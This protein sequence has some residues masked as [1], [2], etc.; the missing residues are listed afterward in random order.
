MIYSKLLVTLSILFFTSNSGFD[1]TLQDQKAAAKILTLNQT[2]DRPISAGESHHYQL[3]LN[4]GDFARVIINQRAI[5]LVETVTNSAG[6]KLPDIDGPYGL[7]GPETVLI[8]AETPGNYGIEVKTLLKQTTTG[9]YEIRFAELRT[10][11]DADKERVAAQ[12]AFYEAIQISRQPAPDARQKSLA[13]YETALG[14]WRKVADRTGE[15]LALHGI[16]RLH[17]MSGDS[18]KA[19]IYLGQAL[20]IWRD[21]GIRQAEAS[22]LNNIGISHTAL[23]D[24]QQVVDNLSQSLVLYRETGDRRGEAFVNN[25]LCLSYRRLGDYQ[26]ALAHCQQSLDMQRAMGD[27]RSE[28]ENLNNLGLVHKSLGDYAKALEFFSQS[29]EIKRSLKDQRGQLSGLSNLGQIYLLTGDP[30]KALEYHTQALE[31]SRSVGERRAE[32]V[33]FNNLGSVH[34][35]LGEH[36]RALEYFRQSL[37]LRREITDRAGEA[38]VLYS[39]ATTYRQLGNVPEARKHVEAALEIIESLRTAVINQELRESYF[40]T[41][42]DIYEFYVGLLMQQHKQEP[43]KGFDALALQANERARARG[44]IDLLAESNVD[45]RAGVNADLLDR[46]RSLQ[47]QIST[48]AET[49]VRLLSG[50]AAPERVAA[51]TKELHNLTTEYAQVRAQIKMQ[52]PRYA[53]LTEPTQL[54]VRDIQQQVLDADTVLLEYSLGKDRSFLWLVG[55]RSVATFELPPRE[56]IEKVAQRAHELLRVSN[57]RQHKREAELAT[58]ELSKLVLGPVVDKLEQKRLLVVADGALQYVP[59]AALSN[60]Q[61]TPLIH[62]HEIVNLP[63]ASVLAILRQ[64]QAQ[65]KRAEKMVAVLADPVLQRADERVARRITQPSGPVAGARIEVVRGLAESAISFERLIHSRK[66]AEAILSFSEGG[67]NLKALDFDAS[68]ATATSNALADYRI[69]HFAT[70]GVVNNE[71][72]ALSGVVLSLVDKRGQMLDGF[73]RLHDIYNLKLGSDLVV[74]S[75]C[76][77]ALGKQV[78]GEGLIGLVR[79]FMYAGAPRVVATSWDVKDEATA[80]LMKRFYKNMLVDNRTPAAALRAAQISMSKESRWSSPYFWAGFVI[81]G[82]FK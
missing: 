10:A 51:T 31:L 73:L 1:D 36:E 49:Q 62:E 14:L 59:F 65:R 46:E 13:K 41:V 5:D 44:L 33:V 57:Q 2:I 4:A 75:A 11:T 8:F 34:A 26:R 28:G 32:S 70:H 79:G 81:Q 68:R 64:E 37:S 53:E 35:A 58:L 16:G 42:Q 78:K 43:D 17:G 9:N 39:T 77:T 12:Q 72:P 71:Y 25:N 19:L 55:H 40:A 38:L 23:G 6:Q 18:G 50:K 74:L 3:A 67:S 54:T 29:L 56:S 15:G 7:N 48:K 80:E 52:S 30:R 24:Y 27:Q 66:E 82:E 22:A 63:S 21:L 47:K 61:G 20:A 45:I 69:V 76:Q 60:A